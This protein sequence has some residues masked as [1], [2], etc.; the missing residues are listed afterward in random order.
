MAK[1][2]LNNCNK[3][4]TIKGIENLGELL[5]QMSPRLEPDSFSFLSFP[6]AGYGDYAY[7]CPVASILEKEGITLVVARVIALGHGFE[8]TTP[9]SRIT[10][11]VHSSLTAVGLTAAVSNALASQ[12]ISVNVIAGFYHDYLYVPQVDG[13]RALALLHELTRT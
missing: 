12:G 5:R 9:F 7:L 13:E 3:D 11:T 10:L 4:N 6:D 1:L 2:P 8:D